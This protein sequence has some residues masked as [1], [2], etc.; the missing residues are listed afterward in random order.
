MTRR[1]K[2]QVSQVDEGKQKSV[3]RR[4]LTQRTRP[5]VSPW[6]HII[7]LGEK[8]LE[9]DS[10]A[11]QHDQIVEAVAHLLSCRA[12]LWLDENLFRLPG[13][14]HAFHFSLQPPNDA[15]CRAFETGEWVCPSNGETLLVFPVKNHGVVLGV[16]QVKRPSG[17]PFRKPEI[18]SLKGVVGHIALSLAFSHRHAVEQWRIE[19]L[20]LVRRVSAQIAQVHN[21]DE[22]TSR[23]TGLIQH[24]FHYYYVA[25]F[26]NEPGQKK[27]NFRSSAGPIKS[28][29]K[30]RMSP[31]LDV[32]LGEGL[33]G[34]VALSGDEAVINDIQ[35]E[36][37]FRF[38]DSLPETRS[39][40]VL[41]LKIEERILGVLDVQ[42]DMLNVF[43]PN[44]LLVL[45]ALADNIAIAMDGARMYTDL[46]KAAQQLAIVAEVSDDI[47][48]ILDLDT[49][50]DK[51]ATLIHDRLGYPY[52]HLF[53]VHLNRR[54]II[55]EAG[56]GERSQASHGYILDLDDVD[57]IIPRVARNGQTL[58]ANDV[59]KEPSYRS[60]PFLPKNTLSEIAVPLIYDNHVL[61]VLDLQSDKLNAFTKD[62]QFLFEAL[63][64]NI[65]AAIQNADL[66]RSELWRRQVTDSLREVA[67]LLSAD[68]YVDD[69][70]DAILKELEHNLP[71]DVSAIW[72]LNGEELSLEHIHGA[73][74]LEVE[75][76]ARRWPEA[77]EFLNSALTAGQPV[78]RKPTDPFDPT[79]LVRGFS[80]DY[81][82][83][84]A[85]LRIGERPLGVLTL[86]HRTGG[87]YGHES[88]SMTTTFANYAAV[89]I[90][91]AR[92]YDTAQ[93]QAYASAALLQV[94]QTVA[95][96]SSLDETLESV[97]R[98]MP[99][100]VGVR[101]CAIYLLESDIFR[102]AKGYG[103]SDDVGFILLGKDFNPGEFSL[104]DAVRKHN[105]MV[106]GLLGPDCP[107]NCLDPELAINEAEILNALQIGER[108]LIGFP[109]MIKNDFYG[110]L[111][112][113]E[114]SEALRFRQKRM[115]ILN[116]VAQQVALTIQNE[117]FQHEMVISERLE[118]EVQVARQIQKTLLPQ[119]L[120]EF[121]GWELAAVWKTAR[122]VGGDYYDV[123]ELPD[124]RL[125]L[126]I[127][128]V[129]DKG[130]PAALFMALTRTLVRAVV[131]NTLSPAEVLR[132]VNALMIPDNQQEM[133][134]T[135]VYGVLSVESGNFTY[136]NAGH[137]PP[138]WACLKEGTI[139]VLHRTGAALGI[140]DDFVMEERTIQL[141]PGNFLLLYT[142]GLTEAF[143]PEEE[144]YGEER[145]RK[146]VQNSG[147][148]SVQGML[149]AIEASVDQFM[150]SLPAVDDMTILA[151]HR[152]D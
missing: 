39:E 111:M 34:S 146:I 114:T 126:L 55:Y 57:G 92:L 144:L 117:H 49:L 51:V 123:F 120:P 119:K 8:L 3:I 5:S 1:E 67:G 89:A 35:S 12:D 61:G 80:A 124:K 110:V 68:I 70:L 108:M 65:A 102:S 15:M 45:R 145:L 2:S 29:R 11:V 58:L 42:S 150:N 99:I 75:G 63:A 53:T 107:D 48:S 16:L 101:G 149:D 139:E 64:G 47:N 50:L 66:Y 82:S 98:I 38:I 148:D 105:R 54:Q 151:I 95:N 112:V 77:T 125:G 76:A 25:I 132:R 94:A 133:F 86:S 79:G 96:S 22:L 56:R 41:P 62:D 72:F 74:K 10:I 152:V 78:I 90:E 129:S 93:E 14:N 85:G 106:I 136:A 26:T 115:E 134:V 36:P 141:K 40:V 137:N 84:I 87:R 21:L 130:V 83:I 73:N 59:R 44:D 19:Q 127:A 135:A 138:L 113:E 20:T 103:I 9:T 7:Q 91:N 131:Y 37:R 147:T 32:F 31:S 4:K 142:D 128:D 122:Q 46:E 52:V 116:G 27:L 109:L 100:L 143:S 69:V 28:R 121:P 17:F 97:A 60:S 88:L 33:I 104:L 71:C 24:T 13:R 140:I 18:E 30:K 43:H 23:I 6:S 118:Q 81:S